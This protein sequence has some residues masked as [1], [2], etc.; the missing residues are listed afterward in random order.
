MFFIL[1]KTIYFIVMPI[2]LMVVLVVISFFIK[3]ASVKR[4]MRFISFGMLIFFSNPFLANKVMKCWEGVPTPFEEVA[5]HDIG[6]VL[7]GITNRNKKPVDRVFYERGA[8]RVLHTIQLY[9]LNKIDKILISG[10][11]GKLIN[12]E[13][14]IKEAVE[15]SQTFL[16]A[17]IPEKDILIESDSRNTHESAVN[18]SKIIQ[19]MQQGK[20]LLITSAFHLKR[21]GLCFKKENITYTP[22]GTD[23]Y[24]HDEMHGIDEYITPKPE[25]IQNWNMVI[26]EITGIAVYKLMGYV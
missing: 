18:C 12:N 17:G 20:V 11:S 15:L 21:S 8:D 23:Y 5:H 26:K 7:T 19:E 9:K 14:D 22:F 2:P 1:S 24:A 25:S 13:N 4:K 6:I 10:G 3:T 16:L